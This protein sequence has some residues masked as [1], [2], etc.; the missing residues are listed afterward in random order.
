L[1]TSLDMNRQQ[2]SKLVLK[3]LDKK[4]AKYPQTGLINW[5]EPWQFL[6]CVIL[7]AQANDDQ[8]NKVTKRLFRK[9][10]SLEDFASADL[11]TLEKYVKQA[12]FFR[13][14]ANYLKQSAQRILINFQGKVPRK[15]EKLT[16]LP[17]VGRKSANCYQQVIFQKSEGIA[18]DTHVSR[19][20]RRLDLS[21]QKTADKIEKDLMRLFPKSKYHR[22]NPI[23]FWHGRM[24]CTARKPQCDKCELNDFCP[25]AFKV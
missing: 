9:F 22:I 20:S 5:K 16:K 12:G 2:R 24:I 19:M 13:V 25:S 10:K 17:G 11:R 1:F 4:Y 8:I 15:L 3:R 18:V 14:K 21:R 7:S 23:L 6:F